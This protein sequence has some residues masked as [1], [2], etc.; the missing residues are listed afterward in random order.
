MNYALTVERSRGAG[1]SVK[2]THQ[3][4][5]S[6][7]VYTINEMAQE[8]DL[9]LRAL[10]FYEDRGLIA[11]ERRGLSRLYR[12][13]DRQ[14]LALIV[15]GKRLG[16][17]L[18][19]I[20]AML[21]GLADRPPDGPAGLALTLEQCLAQIRG[22]ETQKSE[23]EAAIAELRAAA[24]SMTWYIDEQADKKNSAAD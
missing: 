15:R 9:S 4:S 21:D 2:A 18:T 14:R 22:L 5:E 11:P 12:D 6:E 17:T 10:R 1:R 7:P 8:F 3:G 16:F 24:D 20:S 19:E 23:I 13:A